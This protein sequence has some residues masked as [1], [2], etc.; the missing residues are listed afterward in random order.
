MHGGIIGQKRN[1]INRGDLM[2]LLYKI[3]DRLQ[4]ASISYIE[5]NKTCVT[6][7][8]QKTLCTLNVIY[9]IVV[10]G[11]FCASL[12]V[13]SEWQVTRMYA[14]AVIL[15]AILLPA[16]LVRYKTKVKS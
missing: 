8:N 11:Y 4:Q 16:V 3:K 1:D 6:K 10:F 13:F 12:N 5:D 9:F 7:N 14:S 15:H 2:E